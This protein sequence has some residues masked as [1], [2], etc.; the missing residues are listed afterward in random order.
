MNGAKI[1]KMGVLLIPIAI[2][3]LFQGCNLPKN[4]DTAISGFWLPKKYVMING[5]SK[6]V[7]GHISFGSN[8]WSVVFFILDDDGNPMNASAEGGEYLLEKNNLTF[9][10]SYN[11]SDT[12]KGITGNLT[13]TVS[14]KDNRQKEFCHIELEEDTLVIYFPSGNAMIFSKST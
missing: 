13:K 8:Q 11:F 2:T 12:S 6:D 4:T 14:S 5:E 10:H 7:S 9:W 3:F 1:N